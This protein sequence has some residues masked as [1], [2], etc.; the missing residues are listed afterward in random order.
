MTVTVKVEGFKELERALHELPNKATAKN[1]MKRVLLR[2]G[3]PVA[4]AARANVPIEEGWLQESID[5]SG[6][7]SRRQR[8]MHKKP[9]RDEVEVFIGPGPDPAAHLVEFGSSHQRAQPFLRPAWDQHKA[10][11]LSG[12]ANDMWAEIQSAAARVARKAA[13]AAARAAGR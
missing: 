3:E 9:H 11:V 5:V 8:S 13:R 12:I 2:R 1:V 10:G 6:K 4:R 7:L